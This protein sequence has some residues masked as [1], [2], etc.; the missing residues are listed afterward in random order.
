MR[1]NWIS[2]FVNRTS[3]AAEEERNR[4]LRTLVFLWGS[5]LLSA[6]NTTGQWQI[7]FFSRTNSRLLPIAARAADLL[8]VDAMWT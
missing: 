7:P 6:E 4:R 8:E 3:L 1:I 2:R 5:R